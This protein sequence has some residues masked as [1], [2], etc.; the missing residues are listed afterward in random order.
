MESRCSHL[1]LLIVVLFFTSIEILNAQCEGDF[2]GL[3]QQCS[4]YVQKSGPK[5][6]PSESCC[7][8]LKHVDI[9]CICRYI[10]PDMEHVI[11]I[12]K[13]VYVSSFCGKPIPHGTKCGSKFSNHTQITHTFI[14]YMFYFENFNAHKIVTK[15][16]V[17]VLI[18]SI[19]C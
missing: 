1:L 9:P 2:Q 18:F 4:Q 6:T 5:L 14:H 10:D 15:L 8:V 16:Y 11:S 12:E 19:F 7:N 13:A 17:L 3:V